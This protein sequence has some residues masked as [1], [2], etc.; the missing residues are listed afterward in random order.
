MNEF[1]VFAA[2]IVGFCAGGITATI[3]FTILVKR[4]PRG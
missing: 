4:L 2:L 1:A 3:A